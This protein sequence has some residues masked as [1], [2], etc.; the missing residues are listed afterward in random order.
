MWESRSLKCDSSRGSYIM[1]LPCSLS[2]VSA[3][4]PCWGRKQ[5]GLASLK[6]GGSCIRCH[7]ITSRQDPLQVL[8]VMAVFVL[9]VNTAIVYQASLCCFEEPHCLLVD[10]TLPEL[11]AA[12]GG[13]KSGKAGL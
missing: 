5:R 13:E 4:C 8:F 1:W 9:L 10:I 12:S 3:D 11:V 2:P 6:G 7:K